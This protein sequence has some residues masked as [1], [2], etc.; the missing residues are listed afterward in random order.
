MRGPHALVMLFQTPEKG[1]A[2]F[3]RL[4]KTLACDFPA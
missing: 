4:W 2:H 1:L 3:S